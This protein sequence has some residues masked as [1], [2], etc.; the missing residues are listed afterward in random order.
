MTY[1]PE[2][3]F[4]DNSYK[5]KIL[6]NEKI[7]L[8]VESIESKYRNSQSW[9]LLYSTVEHGHSLKTLLREVN[10]ELPPFII[11]IV[12]TDGC[13]FGVYFNEQLKINKRA[14]GRPE[15]FLYTFK[16]NFK[17]FKYSG[18]YPY[19]CLC[20]FEYLA[21][22]CSDGLYGLM[23]DDTLLHGECHFVKTFSNEILSKK[24]KFEIK[25]VEIWSV[26]I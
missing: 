5:S 18:E 8:L 15:T 17:I 1:I 24:S 11:S 2:T 25:C 12:D 6:D 23:V 14:F 20:N 7:K 9:D 22:G 4:K 3:L 26:N 13:I 19:F 16:D 21:F 10:N